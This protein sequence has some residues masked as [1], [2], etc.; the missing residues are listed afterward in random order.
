L[1]QDNAKGLAIIGLAQSQMIEAAKQ[2][3]QNQEIVLPQTR[4][5]LTV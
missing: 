5:G 2:I 1:T 3:P 4:H